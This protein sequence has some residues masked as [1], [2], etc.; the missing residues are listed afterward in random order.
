MI[1]GKEMINLDQ[2][3]YLIEASIFVSAE[4]P[5]GFTPPIPTVRSTN[6]SDPTEIIP[7]T[8]FTHIEEIARR[9]QTYN[10]RE[11]DNNT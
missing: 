3:P 8:Y 1:I 10:Q 11:D 5:G 7:R 4:A 2:P 6:T 9:K